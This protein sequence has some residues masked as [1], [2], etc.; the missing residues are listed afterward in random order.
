MSDDRIQRSKMNYLSS[1]IVA[2]AGVIVVLGPWEGYWA[3]AGLALLAL[4][5]ITWTAQEV[6]P[7]V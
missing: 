7:R 5:V 6:I 2:I 4:G 1:V 3:L